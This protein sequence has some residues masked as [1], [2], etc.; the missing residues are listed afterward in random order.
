MS[1]VFEDYLKKGRSK[2][3]RKA[4][5]ANSYKRYEPKLTDEDVNSRLATYGDALLRLALCKILFEEGCEK[6]TEEKQR[7][8][9]DKVL[10]EV[11][12]K[13]YQLLK[14]LRYDKNDGKIPQNY[15]YKNSNK[16]G[17]DTPHKYIATAVEALLAAI[18][19]DDNE[20]FNVIVGIVRE[21]KTLIDKN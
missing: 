2:N 12:A 14:Y 13:K 3:R 7:Y 8:E 15:V 17:N 20:D 1:I 10:V 21:W 5:T 6:L 4:L 11:V 19:L 9:S 16:K 18:Y